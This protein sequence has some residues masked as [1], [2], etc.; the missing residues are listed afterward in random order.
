MTKEVEDLRTLLDA[1]SHEAGLFARRMGQAQKQ[2]DEALRQARETSGKLTALREAVSALPAL[3]AVAENASAK[4]NQA[5]CEWGPSS[6][7]AKRTFQEEAKAFLELREAEARLAAILSDAPQP[8]SVTSGEETEETSCNLGQALDQAVEARKCISQNSG[9]DREQARE[10]YE[11]A[12]G[13]LHRE[14]VFVLE[15]A[16]LDGPTLEAVAK[17]IVKWQEKNA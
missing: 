4:A 3:R 8:P 6:I 5:R 9:Y 11:H 17:R 12:L 15:N 16:D 10:S 14:I 1:R 7:K 13:D 2:R